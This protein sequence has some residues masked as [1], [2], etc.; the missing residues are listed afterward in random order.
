MI[1]RLRQ[2]LRGH[3]RWLIVV[4]LFFVAMVNNLDRQALSVLAPT[5]REKL[6]FGAIEYSYVVSAFL[7][8]YTIGYAFCGR[9]LDRIGVKL[10]LALALAFW[11]LAGMLHAV[12][13]G[14]VSLAFFRFLLGLG[15]SFNSPA[16]VKALAEWIP[17]RERG[18]SMAVFSNGN[19]VG[20]ILAPP[21]VSFFALHFG[22]RWGFIVTGAMGFVLLAV[23][24]RYFDTPEKH[25]GI[26]EEER[27]YILAAMPPPAVPAAAARLSMWELLRQPI[28]LGFFIARLLTDTTSYFF[29]FWL[30]DYL[31]HERGFT[32]AM[33][34][35]VGWLPFLASDIGGPGGG[36]LS[37]WLVRKGWSSEKARRRLMLGAACLM[38]L[39]I[40]AVR[41]EN[42]WVAIGLIAVLLGAQSCWMTNQLTLI[43]ESVSRANVATLLSLSALG[44][45]LGGVVSSLITGRAVNSYG[46]MPVFTVLGLLHLTAYVVLAWSFR[47]SAARRA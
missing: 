9:V 32:L 46:Y 36:A 8:A 6:G 15:E 18:L 11:S 10:G 43:S 40:V 45:S 41:V 39:A 20:A 25:R 38:P 37:D 33:I 44:G 13:I 34:G 14:W 7:V 24:W 17:P 16:G 35:L 26:T 19:I 30:P 22:W 31:T 5:L 2:F 28:C 21:L 29:S 12:A 27:S 1:A 42:A 47:R 4:L 3:Q 23:W